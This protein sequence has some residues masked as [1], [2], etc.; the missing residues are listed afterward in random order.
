MEA[1]VIEPIRPKRRPD[2]TIH[3]HLEFWWEE[4]IMC[5][6]DVYPLDLDNWSY[7]RSN[8]WCNFSNLC[9]WEEDRRK[10]QGAYA[11]WLLEQELLLKS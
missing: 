6:L 3:T 4:K 11:E 9:W 1:E 8:K 7:Y 5:V 10:V 2:F